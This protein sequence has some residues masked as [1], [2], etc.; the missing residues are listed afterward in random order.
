MQHDEPPDLADFEAR[1]RKA[2][3]SP[4][5][6]NA[7]R[8]RRQSSVGLAQGIRVGMEMLAALLVGGGIG[9]M[10]D[11]WVGSTPAFLI[12]FVMLGLAAGVR[13]ALRAAK[14]VEKAGRSADG[15]EQGR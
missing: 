3:G 12:V 5:T 15:R 13:S 14:Q 10:L 7:D 1:L 6:E 11:Q 8:A 4:S 9:W 2:K